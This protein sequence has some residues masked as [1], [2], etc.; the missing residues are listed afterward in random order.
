M[1]KFCVSAGLVA[2]GALVS[3]AQYAP[4]LS[5]LETTKP[6][7]LGATLRGFYD[8]NY[9]TLPKNIPNPSGGP[10]D[11]KGARGSFGIEAS[12][13][14]SFNHST[15]DTL[16]SASYVYDLR[17]YEDLNGTEDQSHQ[18]NARLDHAFSE[19]YKMALSES[20]VDAQE[21]EV[22]S[23]NVV[24]SPYRVPGNNIANT[25]FADFTAQLTRLFDLHAN[26]QNILY[27][28][29][30]NGG[31]EFGANSYPSYSALLDRIDQTADVDL[32]WKALPDTTGVLGY[33]F[34]NVD[35][36]SPEDIIFSPTA[37]KLNGPGHY[38][39]SSR[40][41]DGHFVYIGADHSFTPLLNVSL[42]AGGEYIDYYHNEAHSLSPYVDASVTY[43]YMPQCTAQL[44]VKHIHNSTD[45]A[46]LVGS[47]PVLDEQS[48][49]IYISDTHR[50]TQKFTISAMGQAQLSTFNGGGAYNGLEEDFY[51]INL[52]LAYAF[53]PWLA[54]EGGYIYNKLNSQ[55]Y[56]RSYSRNE[57]YLGIRATY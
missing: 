17:Y 27:A 53:T 38:V 4:G 28:Y 23:P 35:Y 26:Y 8:D 24:A 7:S 16:L 22:L 13:S 3:H 48:T 11:I 43:Q 34:E 19:R 45:V 44:G 15:S 37:D 50:L 33:Q 21:P 14:L 25:A 51:M 5:P 30:Q 1:K 32:R 47:S 54:G 31:D 40:D 36:T 49:A 42:R 2:L 39:A 52:N 20:F 57:V 41:S 9:L 55:L 12:P 10:Y 46:G 29:Q 56:D 6:W 18:L